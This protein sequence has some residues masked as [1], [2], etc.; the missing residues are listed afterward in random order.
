M[1]VFENHTMYIVV[2]SIY[3]YIYIYTLSMSYVMIQHPQLQFDF[4]WQIC[5]R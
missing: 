5:C 2:Y 3:I 1:Y 4:P